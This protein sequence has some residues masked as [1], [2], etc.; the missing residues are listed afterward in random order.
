MFLSR[1]DV[2]AFETVTF[3]F[4]LR[5]L[6]SEGIKLKNLHLNLN[7]QSSVWTV[8]LIVNMQYSV[9]KKTCV[10]SSKVRTLSAGKLMAP[11]PT[12]V[13]ASIWIS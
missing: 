7:Q 11:S 8:L 12:A 1:I 4:D 2:D 6:K 5:N 9:D 3:T 13:Y 10:P